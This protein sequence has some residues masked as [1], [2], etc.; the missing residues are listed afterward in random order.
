M[1]LSQFLG[2]LSIESATGNTWEQITDAGF[3]T[4]DKVRALTMAQV[5]VIGKEEKRTIGDLRAEKIIT[6][7]NSQRVQGYL[8]HADKWLTDDEPVEA[9]MNA[10]FDLTGKNVCFTGAGPFPRKELTALL[11]RLGANVQSSVNG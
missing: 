4:L 9:P 5:A 6:S 8:L 10:N 7:L 11:K 3:D 1:N 2:S